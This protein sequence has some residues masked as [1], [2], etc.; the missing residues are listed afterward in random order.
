M[1]SRRD[2][3][4]GIDWYQKTRIYGRPHKDPK[5]A[6]RA[7]ARS[8][9]DPGYARF[10]TRY[11]V[12]CPLLH[13]CLEHSAGHDQ[14]IRDDEYSR[15]TGEALSQARSGDL[16]PSQGLSTSEQSHAVTYVQVLGNVWTQC[17]SHDG[18]VSDWTRRIAC[19]T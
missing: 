14:N 17:Y 8:R 16:S 11:T 19:A 4:S 12:Q 15:I 7:H 18:W 3:S 6:V 2:E 5:P 1:Y 10:D 9:T 13:H